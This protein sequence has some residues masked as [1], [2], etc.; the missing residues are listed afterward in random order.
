M[1]APSHNGTLSLNRRHPLSL[2]V[3]LWAG[4]KKNQSPIILIVAWSLG[5]SYSIFSTR[6]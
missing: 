3:S 5:L 2:G 6:A 4:S 1:Q